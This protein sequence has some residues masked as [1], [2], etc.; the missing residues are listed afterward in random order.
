MAV[1]A[2]LRNLRSSRLAG[3]GRAVVEAEVAI[4]WSQ[5]EYIEILTRHGVGVR[6]WMTL[7]AA[8]LGMNR[9]LE[10]RGLLMV[11]GSAGGDFVG[12][13]CRCE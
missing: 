4:R 9:L 12:A 3:E 2:S 13:L 11:A 6:T 8:Q 10:F 5:L 7:L 1:A